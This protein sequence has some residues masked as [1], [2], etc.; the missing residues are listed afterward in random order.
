MRG[1][2]KAGDALMCLGQ[3]CEEPITLRVGKMTEMS[4]ER[5]GD[6][7]NGSDFR[8]TSH[9]SGQQTVARIHYPVRRAGSINAP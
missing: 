1:F 9:C 2:P 5:H 4:C 3:N 8:T 7:I 6:C